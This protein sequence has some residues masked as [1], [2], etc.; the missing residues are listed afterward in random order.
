M[1]ADFYTQKTD[2]YGVQG[3]VPIV[4]RDKLPE[5]AK[6]INGNILR[7]GE[8][9]GHHHIVDGPCQL[10]EVDQP[11]KSAELWVEFFGDVAVKHHEH[12]TLLF[13]AGVYVVP[14]QVEYDGEEE[15]RVL[16]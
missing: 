2:G 13:P 9:T 10:Y 8:V 4:K 6:K 14:D 11:N 12:G 15:R 7:L 16:D 1:Y 5:G 3:D